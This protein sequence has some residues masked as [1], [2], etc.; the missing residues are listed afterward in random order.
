MNTPDSSCIEETFVDTDAFDGA[1]E[2]DLSPLVTEMLR[3]LGEDP[4]RE[5]LV[6]T[7][8]R[9]DQAMKFLTS[10]YHQDLD[11]LVNDAVFSSD[12]DDI[13]LVRDINVFSLCEHHMLPFHGKAHVAYV[14]NGKVIGLSKIPRIVDMFARRLQIQEQLSHQIAKALEAV[15]NPLGVIVIMECEHMCMMMRGVEK[16]GSVTTTRAMTGVFKQDKG[17]RDDALKMITGAQR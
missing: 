1:P 17:L 8:Y 11:E 9:V 7:P 4:D 14:P 16:V 5:G 3:S 13:V 6:K 15:L 10:G 2:G 12:S